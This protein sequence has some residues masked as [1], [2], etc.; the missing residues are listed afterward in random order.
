MCIITQVSCQLQATASFRAGNLFPRTRFPVWIKA[1]LPKRHSWEIWKS[2]YG[3]RYNPGEAG[4]YSSLTLLSYQLPL[5]CWLA[6]HDLITDFTTSSRVPAAP[7]LE[8]KSLMI[9]SSILCLQNTQLLPHL[10][11]LIST[12]NS[13]SPEYLQDYSSDQT[14]T[15]QTQRGRYYGYN[16]VSTL[17]YEKNYSQTSLLI[18]LRVHFTY[19][20][21]VALSLRDSCSIVIAISIPMSG[22][23][24]S[25]YKEIVWYALLFT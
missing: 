17:I 1:S 12:L 20:C 15:D 6:R 8:L 14:W 19:L 7:V 11:K 9:V 13:L 22:Y 23:F 24:N 4:R 2:K 3:G 10:D 16:L 25:C 21:I 18:R 5:G